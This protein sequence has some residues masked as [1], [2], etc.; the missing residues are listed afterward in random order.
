MTRF[1]HVARKIGIFALVAM[2][3]GAL[4]GVAIQK[5][6][7][8]K[9]SA[10]VSVEIAQIKPAQGANVSSCELRPIDSGTE[11]ITQMESVDFAQQIASRTGDPSLASTLPAL[12]FG[13]DGDLRVRERTRESLFQI[14]AKAETPQIALAA[15]RTAAQ[16]LIEDHDRKL[17]ETRQILRDAEDRAQADYQESAKL[18]NQVNERLSESINSAEPGD[19]AKTSMLEMLRRDL[20]VNMTKAKQAYE[21][22]RIEFRRSELKPTRLLTAPQVEFSMLGSPLRM[23]GVGALVG[24]LVTV[25]YATMIGASVRDDGAEA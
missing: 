13:G 18:Y 9:V 16:L 23:A 17:Q 8:R 10:V 20:V 2:G 21:D 6:F 22:A 25:I 3:L 1:A 4:S 12:R 15:V 5:L 24:L 14:R 7:F 11:I 19:L